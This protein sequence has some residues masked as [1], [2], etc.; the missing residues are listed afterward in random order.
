LELLNINCGG[1]RK[2]WIYNE[3]TALQGWNSLELQGCRC[4]TWPWTLSISESAAWKCFCNLAH[5][6][7]NGKKSSYI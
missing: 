6:R 1:R 4:E 2:P 5:S 3:E 7:G